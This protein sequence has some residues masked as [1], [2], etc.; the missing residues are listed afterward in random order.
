MEDG[1]AR[2]VMIQVGAT[3]EVAHLFTAVYPWIGEIT[4]GRIVGEGINGTT[5]QSPTMKFNRTGGDG[6]GINIGRKKTIGVSKIQGMTERDH[7]KDSNRMKNMNKRETMK[8]VDI[9][10]KEFFEE[11]LT[12]CKQNIYYE[13]Q[14]SKTKCIEICK[15]NNPAKRRV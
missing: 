4:T 12:M 5:K 2:G 15:S 6:K 7:D 1:I 3:I 9:K 11:M 13:T 14:I 8:E 10:K